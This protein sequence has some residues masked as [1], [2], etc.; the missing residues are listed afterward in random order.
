MPVPL[1]HPAAVLPLR[2]YCPKHLS[3]SALVIG[4]VVPDVAYAFNIHRSFPTVITACFGSP[5]REWLADR[6]VRSWDGLSHS[7]L[8][9]VV[10]CLP[11]GLL[12]LAAFRLSRASLVATLP[13]PHRDVLAPLCQAAGHSLLTYA[14]SLL[15]GVFSHLAWDSLAKDDWWL[16][17]AWPLLQMEVVD[18]G[19]AHIEVYQAIW[20]ISSVGGTL[21]LVFAYLA[22]LKQKHLAFLV[23]NRQEAPYHFVWLS[24]AGLAG[25]TAVVTCFRFGRMRFSFGSLFHR[26]HAFYAV[27]VTA[28][29]CLIVCIVA[30]AMVKSFLTPTPE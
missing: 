30:V 28:L 3:F 2:R 24:A 23:F 20:I 4:S 25:L 27:F 18:A 22:Y 19:S 29:G 10:F 14:G 11:L 8:G 16:A 21:A 7:L 5:L 12:L 13:N 17:R 15:I 1:A 6:G 26:F 9:S